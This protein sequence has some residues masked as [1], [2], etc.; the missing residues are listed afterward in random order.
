[1]R[2]K[3]IRNKKYKREKCEEE[4][5]STRGRERERNVKKREKCEEEESTRGRERDVKK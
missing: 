5:E 2:N 1:M 3:E 4:T